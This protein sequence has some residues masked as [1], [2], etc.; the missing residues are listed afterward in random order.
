MDQ[1]PLSGERLHEIEDHRGPQIR[2][3]LRG[4]CEVQGNGNGNGFMA[5]GGKTPGD[6]IDLREDI[7][8]V[9]AR[10]CGHL[11]VDDGNFHDPFPMRFRAER[12]IPAIISR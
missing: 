1:A 10:P 6:E 4:R 2:K 9:P 12:M 5:Q 8:F 7:L 11:S 3:R